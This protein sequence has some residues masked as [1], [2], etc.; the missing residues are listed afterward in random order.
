[1]KGPPPKKN[2]GVLQNE[3]SPNERTPHTKKYNVYLVLFV[4]S[5]FF[6]LFIF[7]YKFIYSVFIF[8][9]FLLSTFFL[10]SLNDFIHFHSVTDILYPFL[11]VLLFFI[12][13]YSFFPSR[14]LFFLFINVSFRQSNY[15]F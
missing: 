7:Q 12:Q 14:F 4:K 2:E 6:L 1:M 9:S 15:S 5:F 10:D 3:R 11:S 13:V 8:H